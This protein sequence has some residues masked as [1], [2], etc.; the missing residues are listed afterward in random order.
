MLK[1]EVEKNDKDIEVQQVYWIEIAPSILKLNITLNT[2]EFDFATGR[3]NGKFTVLFTSEK[4]DVFSPVVKI[5]LPLEY[6]KH[7]YIAGRE[8][9]TVT[10][11]FYKSFKGNKYWWC[12]FGSF[13]K[14]C[15]KPEGK[16][17]EGLS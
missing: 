15:G 8:K 5:E 4:E 10:I 6:Q 11:M 2:R 16:I 14:Y 7:C 9:D 13:A 1:I 3:E 12:K 17:F